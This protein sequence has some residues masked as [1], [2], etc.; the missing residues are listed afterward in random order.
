MIYITNSLIQPA[1]VKSQPVCINALKQCLYQRQ[2][3]FK[4][5]LW[6]KNQL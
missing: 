2:F 4:S 3:I 1:T 6:K 5:R